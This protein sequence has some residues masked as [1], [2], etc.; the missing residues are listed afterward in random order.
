MPGRQKNK[1]LLVAI[2]EPPS[3][4]RATMT[5]D[6]GRAVFFTGSEVV[7]NW[8]CGKCERI[9]VSGSRRERLADVVLKC[10]WCGT[11]NDTSRS[12]A[13]AAKHPL[14]ANDNGKAD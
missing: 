3:E 2:K 4:T 14:E 10:P 13:R 12:T 9:L 7:P 11:F 1:L 8:Q 6:I 5:P